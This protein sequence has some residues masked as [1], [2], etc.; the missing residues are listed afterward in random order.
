MAI[1]TIVGRP[2]VGKS[3]LFNRLIGERRA[4]VDDVPGVTRDRLYGQVEWRGNS[5]YLVDTGGL[6]LRDEDP[7]MEGM[8]GQILQAMEESDVILLS[9][10]G[11]E[12]LTWMDEDIAMVIRKGTPKPVVVVVNKLD[13]MKFD[14]L[15]YEAYG[16]GFQDV[17]GISAIH[18]RGIDDLLDRVCELLPEDD[19]SFYE[20]D[21]IKV[22]LVGRPNVGKSSILN[23]LL[24]ENRSLVSDVPGTTRDSIDSLM[25]LDDG[26]KLRLI[27]TAGLRRKSR[28]KDDIEYYSFVRTMESIDRSDVAILVVDAVE[29]VTDQDKKLASSIVERGKG[30]VLVMNKWDLLKGDGERIG[31]EKR[32]LVR[33][34]LVFVNHAPLVF[35]SALTGRGVGAKLLDAVLGVYERRK[36]RFST[37][38]LNGLLRDVLAFE[39]L[40]SDK[41]GKLLRIYYCTQAGVEPPMFVFF[42]NERNIVTRSFENHMINQ[43]RRLGDYDGVPIRLFWRNSDGKRR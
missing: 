12:G 16:L 37:T 23:R 3:S 11:R 28:F 13:D 41:K 14:E 25:E 36:N 6:L 22:A 30:I 10:D 34:S 8:K 40:P 31:D 43:I 2:N 17:V 4:I 33:D 5:F 39:R 21:E 29:G 38:K 35:C 27:D 20:E 24:G 32:D 19:R 26:R 9:V 7:I 42:V 15:V 1:V 18:A